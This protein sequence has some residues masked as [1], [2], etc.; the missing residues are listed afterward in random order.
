MWKEDDASQGLGM[1]IV[2]VKAGEATLAMTVMP[3]M[4]NGQRIAHGGVFFFVEGLA[5]A[6]S[7]NSHKLRAVAAPW[8][9]AFIPPGKPRDPPG[10]TPP[11]NSPGGGARLL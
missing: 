10:A 5:F 7:R 11:A 8:D 9:I 2:D 3:H 6:F 4:V 1:E